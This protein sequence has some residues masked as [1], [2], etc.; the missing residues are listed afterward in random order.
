MN[1]FVSVSELEQQLLP[2]LQRELEY[3]ES[4]DDVN[5]FFVY[6]ARHILLRVLAGEVPLNPDD[7]KLKP[8]KPPFYELGTA[9]SQHPQFQQLYEQA[10]LNAVLQRLAEA[11]A[12]RYMEMLHRMSL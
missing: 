10:E 12:K 3:T 6:N 4:A 9:I 8:G 5:K 7:I 2:K 11:S 1:S